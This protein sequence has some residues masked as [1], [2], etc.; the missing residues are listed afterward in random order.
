MNPGIYTFHY[1]GSGQFNN[2][3]YH[4]HVAQHPILSIIVR[5][6]HT[7]LGP[8]D[9]SSQQF[10]NRLNFTG[11]RMFDCG[12]F[13]SADAFYSGRLGVFDGVI[14]VVVHSATIKHGGEHFL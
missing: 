10:C 9:N 1:T 12:S 5:L 14:Y 7:L 13:H 6:T 4:N 11:Y 8:L 2:A 3:D